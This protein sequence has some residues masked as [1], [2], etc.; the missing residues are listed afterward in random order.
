M[1]GQLHFWRPWPQALLASGWAWPQ[2]KPSAGRRPREESG[3]FW[4]LVRLSIKSIFLTVE[5]T[6]SEASP[7]SGR[8]TLLQYCF[9]M[10]RYPLGAQP[11][12]LT[13]QRAAHHPAFVLRVPLGPRSLGEL[14]GVERGCQARAPMG[15]TTESG[16]A[17][18]Q[19]APGPK[20]WAERP[21]SCPRPAVRAVTGVDSPGLT[22]A[23]GGGV[24]FVC[25]APGKS[26]RTIPAFFP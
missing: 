16:Q 2:W 1:V 23:P 8:L 24:L 19:R 25:P 5:F 15:I 14:S 7:S 20:L 17:G 13:G 11:H 6:Y 26:H 3:F 22:G 10:G 18:C 4:L 21:L 12:R 9:Q